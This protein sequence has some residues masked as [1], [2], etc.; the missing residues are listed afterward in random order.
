DILD[1]FGDISDSCL[2]NISV[3]IRS[4]VVTEQSE[5]QLIYEAYS[6]FVQGLFELMD[7]VAE[8]A[9]VL[10]V[11]DKQAEFRVPAAVREL[12]GVVDAFQMQVM[13]VFP[14]NTSYAQQTANQKSQVGT[15]IRQAVHAFHIA[16]ANTGSPYSNTT[17]V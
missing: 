2:S 8:S 6:N 17:T 12:A 10:I 13:A 14:A 16:T 9:P 15:H 3:M 7:A 11:L 5:H 4:S 1:E